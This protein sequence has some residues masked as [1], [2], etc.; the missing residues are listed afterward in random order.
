VDHAKRVPE[1][2]A[3]LIE[4]QKPDELVFWMKVFNVSQQALIGAVVA[5]G[6]RAQD[7][8]DY[9]EAQE[10]FQRARNASAS[11][12]NASQNRMRNRSQA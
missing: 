7:V 11:D 6:H 3:R 5:V 2:D 8:K 1:P 4:L 10:A 9:L 12:A